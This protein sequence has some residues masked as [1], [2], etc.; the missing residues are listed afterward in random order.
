MTGI[1]EIKQWKCS[2]QIAVAAATLESKLGG[3]LA[4]TYETASTYFAFLP[5]DQ[6]YLILLLLEKEDKKNGLGVAAGLNLNIGEQWT[7]R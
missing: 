7:E 5:G 4:Y 6:P 1:Y 3:V 2:Q